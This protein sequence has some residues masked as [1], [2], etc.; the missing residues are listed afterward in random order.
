VPLFPGNEHKLTS[1]SDAQCIKYRGPDA[2]YNGRDI[3]YG[4]N[5]DT[6]TIYDATNKVGKTGKASSII[7]RTTYTGASYTH[8][9]WTI[10]PLWQEY[11]LMNDEYDEEEARG[12]AADGY[13]V[14]FI[15]SPSPRTFSL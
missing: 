5:E 7:S 8:Q 15:V 3:C 6:L 10:D 4:Y 1:G 2:K 11:L 12:P 9:G 14:T 13:P